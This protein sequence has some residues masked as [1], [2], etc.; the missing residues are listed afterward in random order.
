[1]LLLEKHLKGLIQ[2]KPTDMENKSWELVLCS[3]AEHLEEEFVRDGFSV[4][5]SGRNY[6]GSRKFA[7]S[8][9][10][11]RIPTV[12]RFQGKKVCVIQSFTA[13]GES[14]KNNFTTGDRIIEALQML[15]ILQ[16]PQEVEDVSPTK[17]VYTKLQPP[18][19]VVLLAL[20][21]PFSKQDKIYTTGECSS[22]E[23]TISL[24]FSAGAN[25]IVTIDPHV[26]LDFEW[27]KKY[28]DEGKIIVLSMYERVI[29][30][31]TSHK[32]LQKIRFVNTPGKKR[33]NLGLDLK[34]VNKQR[35]NTNS[36]LMEGDLGEDFTGQSVFLI[37]DMVISGTTIQRAR[38]MFL[39]K[40]ASEVYCYIT[41][42]LP[43][44]TGK[45]EN[46]RGLVEAFDE[47]IFVSNTIRTQTFNK[48]FKHCCRSVVPLV[49]EEFF[50]K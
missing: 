27:F 35:I 44:E 19:E 2:I 33:T 48:D 13:S 12:K 6:D 30:E 18:S 47:K 21:M 45:E 10:F 46:L 49:V 25:R 11:S 43:Y 39:E 17:R 9:I 4:I 38:K 22:S 23:M 16:N 41:H 1:M 37:D 34:E 5:K 24:L 7:N 8:D 42:A 29:K 32:D 20:H 28:L 3:G 14:S 15:D 40:G 36:V 50:Y 26:P 31:L